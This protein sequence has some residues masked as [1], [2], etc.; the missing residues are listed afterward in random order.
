M[1]AK[2]TIV[3][4]VRNRASV[5]NRTLESIA[6]AARREKVDLILVDNGSTD[7]SL[8]ICSTFVTT[9]QGDFHRAHV[10]I[11]PRRGA[12]VARNR[13]LE[14]CETEWVYFFDSDDLMSEDFCEAVCHELRDHGGELDLLAFPVR[15]EVDG[16]IRVKDYEATARTSVHILNSMLCTVAM[17]MRTTWLRE[18]GGWN[19]ELTTWDDW[20][21]GTRLLMAH[22]RLRWMTQRAFH[23]IIVQEESQTGASFTDTLAPIVKAMRAVSTDIREAKRMDEKERRS[24]EKALYVRAR[25]MAGKLAHEGSSEGRQAFREIAESCLPKASWQMRMRG[26]LLETYSAAGGRGAWRVALIGSM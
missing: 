13:G 22:P 16:R 15:M 21:L 25:I 14:A 4:P 8:E 23:R 18:Q 7:G 26:W 5:L 6:A 3:V 1:K 10:L 19:E 12:S 20:E 9:H 2:L 17:S 24:C 11:E